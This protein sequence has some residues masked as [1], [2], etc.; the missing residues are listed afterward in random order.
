MERAEQASCAICGNRAALGSVFTIESVRFPVCELCAG[1]G[2]TVFKGGRNP[3]ERRCLH[4]I[5][6]AVE[7]ALEGSEPREAC[8]RRA[9][10]IRARLDGTGYGG[11][12]QRSLFR[13]ACPCSAC[14]AVRD[15][16]AGRSEAVRAGFPRLTVR[17]LRRRLAAGDGPPVLPSEGEVRAWPMVVLASV[18]PEQVVCF[19]ADGGPWTA[20]DEVARRLIEGDAAT[21]RPPVGWSAG[22]IPAGPRRGYD[23]QADIGHGFTLS[24]P[25]W[26][27]AGAYRDGADVVD[28]W[29][30]VVPVRKFGVSDAWVQVWDALK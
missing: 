8:R 23:G 29:G 16:S 18:E 1:A 3:R 15:G 24:E 26:S 5:A 10:T 17:G 7:H 12:G 13:Q 4:L 28:A 11:S 21:R 6:C 9:W 27:S 22:A 19:A 2:A 30:E 20:G 14:E 25:D